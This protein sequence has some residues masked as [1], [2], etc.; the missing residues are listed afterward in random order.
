MTPAI[1]L[2]AQTLGV[3]PTINSENITSAKFDRGAELSNAH[4]SYSMKTCTI[5]R[6]ESVFFAHENSAG[7]TCPFL[8]KLSKLS[9]KSQS[10]ANKVSFIVL[11]SAVF[12]FLNKHMWWDILWESWG[13]GDIHEQSASQ[14]SW[15]VWAC[16]KGGQSGNRKWNFISMSACVL[17][18]QDR[19]FIFTSIFCL[20]I[21]KMDTVIQAER[22]ICNK[23]CIWLCSLWLTKNETTAFTSESV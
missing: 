18:G 13:L 7:W 4:L 11:L 19:H 8:I 1:S 9:R 6:K 16:D 17:T 2:K 15:N 5:K 23:W 21:Q 3:S 10:C 20:C 14:W 12:V 22:R